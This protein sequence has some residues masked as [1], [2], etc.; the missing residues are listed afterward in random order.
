VPSID[1]SSELARLPIVMRKYHREHS[2]HGLIEALSGGKRS[3]PRPCCRLLSTLAVLLAGLSPVTTSA[4]PAPTVEITPNA[5]QKLEEP[6]GMAIRG[7]GGATLHVLVLRSCDSNPATPE[8]SSRGN[9]KT[10]LWRKRVT[11]DHKGQWH[12]SLRLAEL[13]EQPKDEQ[14]WLRVSTDPDGYG[15]CGQ[16]IFTIRSRGS[17]SLGETF[18]SLFSGGACTVGSPRIIIMEFPRRCGETMRRSRA[19]SSV[20]LQERSTLLPAAVLLPIAI[21]SALGRAS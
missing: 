12:D 20:D 1:P 8:L 15:P 18:A 3:E 7:S 19:R 4:Q 13:P 14:L 10:P 9:C 6:M 5:I 21:D 2:L 16:T 11:L 17:C